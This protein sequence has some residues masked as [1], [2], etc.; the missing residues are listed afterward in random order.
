[1]TKKNIFKNKFYTHLDMK[2]RYENYLKCISNPKRIESHGFYPF[3]HYKI[4]FDKYS[5]NEETGEKFIKNKERNIFYSSHIDRFI[6]QYYGDKINDV[7]NKISIEKG[8]GKVA[9]AYRNNL[10]GKCNIHFAKEALEF[11]VKSQKAFIFVGD[12]TGF[13]DNL[14]HEYLKEKLK[15]VLEVHRLDNDYFAV[16]KNITKFTYVEREDIEKVKGKENKE[17]RKESKYFDTKE[18]REFKKEYLKR[19]DNNYGIPQGS[20]ISSVFSNIYMIEFDKKLN[21]YVTSNRG[22]YRRYCDDLIIIIPMEENEI[23]QGVYDKHIEIIDQIR[24]CIPRLTLN[25]N[26]TEQFYYNKDSDQKLVNLKEGK[27]ILDYLGFSFDGEF[28]RIREKS[29]FKYYC[30]AY[31]KIRSFKRSKGEIN[32]HAIKKSLFRLYTHLGDKKYN[33]KA[34]GNF[35]TYARKSEEIFCESKYL[36]SKIN[37][38]VKR[39]WNKISKKLNE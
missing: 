1:M 25:L 27:H 15:E 38:Q 30:R 34:Y 22:M 33:T 12:F 14:E 26:K 23:D 6:Y 31:K 19:N 18:F 5:V 29:L 21:D 32:E 10:F 16:F 35:L 28:V 11:I 24:G 36:N 37:S 13:F 17:F 39:H 2:K 9:T 20:S 4:V 8:I 7:Y 3:I